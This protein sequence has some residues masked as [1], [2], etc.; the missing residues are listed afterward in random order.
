MI[1]LGLPS[2][3]KAIGKVFVTGSLYADQKPA[4]KTGNMDRIWTRKR[5]AIDNSFVINRLLG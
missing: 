1:S 5:K 3:V 2:Q 4:V